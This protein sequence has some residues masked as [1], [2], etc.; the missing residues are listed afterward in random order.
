MTQAQARGPY[1]IGFKGTVDPNVQTSGC[2]FHTGQRPETV[3]RPAAPAM[4]RAEDGSWGSSL[5]ASLEERYGP[6]HVFA[7]CL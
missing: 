4:Q 1:A 5:K 2:R 7:Q 3:Q 6:D